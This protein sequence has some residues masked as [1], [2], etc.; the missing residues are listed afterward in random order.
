[1]LGSSK[2]LGGRERG[3]VLAIS[4]EDNLVDGELTLELQVPHHDQLLRS[5][6]PPNGERRK[7]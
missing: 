5:T 7:Y 1:M 6:T 3:N 4:Q 2:Y